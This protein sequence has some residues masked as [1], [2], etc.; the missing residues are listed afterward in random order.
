VQDGR[1]AVKVYSHTE[2]GICDCEKEMCNNVRYNHP[3]IMP[4]QYAI[5]YRET[6]MH[7]YP[8]ATCCLKTLLQ[9]DVPRDWTPE[10]VW[11]EFAELL[12]ALNHIHGPEDGYGYHF[13]LS[14]DAIPVCFNEFTKCV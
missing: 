5:F 9:K 10:F 6:Y 7:I 1:I 11:N 4:L 2:D 12:S 13:D 8:L 3:K 14:T